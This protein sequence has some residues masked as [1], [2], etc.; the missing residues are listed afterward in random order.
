MK[1]NRLF[2]RAIVS[3]TGK[4]NFFPKETEDGSKLKAQSSK[5]K[6]RRIALTALSVLS[7][8]AAGTVVYGLWAH[9]A[10]NS[11]GVWITDARIDG[12]VDDQNEGS[13]M[14]RVTLVNVSPF[15][16][17][18]ALSKAGCSPNNSVTT[19]PA[20]LTCY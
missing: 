19:V 14:V 6:G 15:A 16:K 1:H 4:R 10:A 20:H 8:F 3:I 7:F 18:F 5:L 17:Q 12:V 13:T 11:S 2:V 9:V